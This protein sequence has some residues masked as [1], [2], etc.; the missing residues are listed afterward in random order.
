MMKRLLRIFILGIMAVCV[1]GLS[2]CSDDEPAQDEYF[3]RY[4]MGMSAEGEVYMD[5]R[6]TDGN[7]VIQGNYP[8]GTVEATVGP[9]KKGFEAAVAA[10]VDGNAPE[11]LK[12]E[13]S[14]GSEPFVQ[15]SYLLHGKYIYCTVGEDE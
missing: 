13:V 6:G 7:H 10:S 2:A 11:W 5:Y 1:A 14:K 15:K 12:I 4:S 8:E 3:V 9:V